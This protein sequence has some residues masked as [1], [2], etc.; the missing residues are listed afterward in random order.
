[1]TP[2]DD[3]LFFHVANSNGLRPNSK[4]HVPFWC[5][6]RDPIRVAFGF[7]TRGCGAEQH[8]L[9][10]TNLV[11][12]ERCVEQRRSNALCVFLLR[13]VSG[14]SKELADK[15]TLLL[16]ESRCGKQFNPIPPGI[17]RCL[18]LF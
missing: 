8:P 9:Q 3:P 6:D 17:I 11:S 5:R 4:Q 7:P 2:C 1:M 12:Q 18:K 16:D 14:V 10:G 15:P 13:G